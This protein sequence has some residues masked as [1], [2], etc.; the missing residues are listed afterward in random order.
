MK[1][2]MKR[3][4]A[5]AA[6]VATSVL[7]GCGG[8]APMNN[9]TTGAIAGSV[10]GGVIGHQFGRGDGNDAAT[11]AGA[12]L[13]GYIGSQMGSQ[14]D[15]QYLGQAVTT[16][17]P[18]SWQNPETGYRYTATPGQTYTN[19]NRVCKKVMVTG[20]SNGA[21]QNVQMTACQQADGSWATQ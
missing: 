21:P 9:A 15:R 10:I 1:H 8:G 18:V 5:G 11:I 13:G 6:I 14:Y 12:I 4:V 17:R 20:Y 19:N 3:I 2:S 7:A 16:G